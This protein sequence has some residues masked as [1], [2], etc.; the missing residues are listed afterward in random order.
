VV[1]SKILTIDAI[2]AAT[3]LEVK[4]VEVSEWGGSVKVKGMTKREQQQLR[5]QATDPLTGQIDPDRM[6]ILMLAHCLAEPLVT[7]EQAEQLAQKSATAFDKVLTAVMDVTG[8]SE[9]AQKAM[10]RTFHAG[11]EGPKT[12]S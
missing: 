9:S 4:V 5:K 1:H 6:E 7:I 2:L 12:E 8:L 10:V 11:D 3:D